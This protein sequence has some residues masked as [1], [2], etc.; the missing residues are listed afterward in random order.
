MLTES[1]PLRSYSTQPLDVSTR[2]ISCET[3]ILT[4]DSL[5]GSC[6]KLLIISSLQDT[7]S[8]QICIWRGGNATE[9]YTLGRGKTQMMQHTEDILGVS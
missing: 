4:H 1:W 3:S 6:N 9:T 2:Y 7:N 5:R 8:T